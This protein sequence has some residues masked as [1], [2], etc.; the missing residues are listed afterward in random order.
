MKVST[1]SN[2]LS[3][4]TGK[5]NSIYAGARCYNP[6][7]EGLLK[8]IAEAIWDDPALKICPSWVRTTLAERDSILFND[9]ARNWV[10][11][12]FQCP[13]GIARSWPELPEDVRASYCAPNRSGDHYWLRED[14]SNYTMA[15]KAQTGAI[16]IRK[17]IVTDRKW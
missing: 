6:T 16:L 15:R 11:W 5:L 10:T 17:Y 12:L 9:I 3:R 1:A 8:Q 7:H 2:H 13:D 14:P 4:L